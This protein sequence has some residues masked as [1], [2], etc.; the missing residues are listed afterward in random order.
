MKCNCSGITFWEFIKVKRI[1][2]EAIT[3]GDIPGIHQNVLPEICR[4]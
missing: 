4:L 3:N 2:N 1:G